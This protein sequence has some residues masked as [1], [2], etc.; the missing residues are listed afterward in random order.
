MV[1]ISGL[2]LAL[3]AIIIGVLVIAFPKL[4]RWLIGLYFIVWGLFA[5]FGSVVA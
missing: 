4:L 1:A 3:F 2:I 5:L